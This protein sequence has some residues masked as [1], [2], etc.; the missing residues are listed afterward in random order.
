ML[1]VLLAFCVITVLQTEIADMA[2]SVQQ[3]VHGR[4]HQRIV[5][6]FPEE[7]KNLLLNDQ[8]G[9]EVH[10]PL[11]SIATG[12]YCSVL[13][14]NVV[15]EYSSVFTSIYSAFGKSLCT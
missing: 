6:Q 14:S 8:S 4:Y 12:D 1:Y 15:V 10:S 5:A 9:S 13:I 3:L 2:Q 7:R 11:Y